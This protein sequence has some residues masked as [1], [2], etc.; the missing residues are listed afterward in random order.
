[1]LPLGKRGFFMFKTERGDTESE[2]SVRRPNSLH[3]MK[4]G[5]TSVGG[6]RPIE[7][8]SNLIGKYQREGQ[9]VVAVVSA[10]RG[11]T[12]NLV[13]VCQYIADQDKANSELV[14][15]DILYK[16]L[17]V[18]TDSNLP[19]PLTHSLESKIEELFFELHTETNKPGTMTPERSDKILSFGERFS[20][21]IVASKLLAKGLMAEPVD[22][23]DILET[24]NH[25]GEASPDFEKTLIYAERVI[26]PLLED[27]I[28][29]VVTGFIGATKD[30]KITTLGRG[31]SDYTASILGKV[32]EANEVWI[33]TDVD[34]IY[35]ADPRY[36]PDAELLNELSQFRAAQ[37][38]RAGARV[39]YPKTLEPLMGTNIVLRI[40]NTFS[41]N[42]EGSKVVH[43]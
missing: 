10:I 24:D 33:W 21:R 40:K 26:R 30:G 38:A 41:P 31:G 17:D 11:V 4:F 9:S 37:M 16:H 12:D 14:L 29:P 1:M 39:L 25:F 19:Q 18:V 36:H 5:G 32:L 6:A 8:V 2:I 23:F 3:V 13:R 20:V 27:G 28:V 34:G 35:T 42:S 7:R 22:A 43:K 15:E